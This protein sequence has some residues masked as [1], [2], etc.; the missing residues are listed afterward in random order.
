MATFANAE[1]TSAEDLRQQAVSAYIDGATKELEAYSRQ[2]GEAVRP[3]NQQQCKEA[4]AKLDECK[5]LV[6]DLKAADSQHFDL[7]KSNFERSRDELVKALEAA[8]K[9]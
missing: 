5:Q 2:I 1:P 9:K 7:I 3:D 8:Q 4:R 6:A